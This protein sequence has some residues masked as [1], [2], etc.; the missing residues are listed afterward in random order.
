MA[1]LSDIEERALHAFMLK[2]EEDVPWRNVEAMSGM[3][4]DDILFHAA[5]A[6]KKL[7]SDE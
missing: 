3:S 1:E 2:Q 5:W 7:R 4:R 6:V